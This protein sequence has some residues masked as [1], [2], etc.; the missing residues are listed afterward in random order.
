MFE[1]EFRTTARSGQLYVD[2]KIRSQERAG[3]RLHRNVG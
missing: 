3:A 2:V 1:I